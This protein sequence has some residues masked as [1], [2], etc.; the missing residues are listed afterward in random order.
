MCV[1]GGGRTRKTR[2]LVG[3]HA[4]MYCKIEASPHL[5]RSRK[6]ST[7]HPIPTH[8]QWLW[9]VT[10]RARSRSHTYNHV[11][12]HTHT[13]RE[14]PEM[15]KCLMDVLCDRLCCLQLV[16]SLLFILFPRFWIL[17]SFDL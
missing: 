3:V 8:T 4:S 5:V 1:G 9:L 12:I 16:G 15:V 6:W 7:T 11:Q 2:C 17:P 14:R 10:P 13:H